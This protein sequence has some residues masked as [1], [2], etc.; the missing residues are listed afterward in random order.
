M[1]V[2]FVRKSKLG[3]SGDAVVNIIPEVLVLLRHVV[4]ILALAVGGARASK[5][6]CW[7]RIFPS[8]AINVLASEWASYS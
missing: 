1:K 5:C 8:H 4:T 6:R 7:R 3:A 2:L